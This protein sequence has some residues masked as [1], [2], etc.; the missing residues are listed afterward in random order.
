[1]TSHRVA[2]RDGHT[3]DLVVHAPP[4]ARAGMLFVPALGVPARK[5][6]AFAQSLASHGIAVALHELRG[7]GTSSVRASR[8]SDWGYAE[9]FDDIHATRETLASAMPGVRWIAS[10]HSLGAQLAAIDIAR[11]PSRYAGLAI[12]AS[13]QPW[14]RTFAPWQQPFVLA[15]F[16][17]FRALSAL[18]GYFPGDKVGFGGREARRV[19]RDWS[20]SGVR[21]RYAP[22]AETALARVEAPVIG[23]HL[24]H[25]AFAPRR[26]LD[27]LLGKMPRAKVLIQPLVPADFE[28][29]RAD[30]FSWLRDPAP[31]AD[32]IAAWII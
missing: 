18:C 25:D 21:G 11:D 30:H 28:S 14:W 23:L 20:R 27:H 24:A 16:G 3:F 31:V 10:G 32:R 5:Y 1:M 15:M 19:I 17:W 26:S 29:R 2:A 12:V 9:L 6:T 4:V 8:A 7:G 22:D 13:G